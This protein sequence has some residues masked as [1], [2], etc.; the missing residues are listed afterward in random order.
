MNSDQSIVIFLSFLAS[1]KTDVAVVT[2]TAESAATGA[3]LSVAHSNVDSAESSK[4]PAKQL[5]ALVAYGDDS[6][7][8]A[9]T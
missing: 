4:K 2:K 8:D 9:D 7:S 5:S 6:D 3:T 1:T